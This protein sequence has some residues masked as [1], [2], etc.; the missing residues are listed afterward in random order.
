MKILKY[1][2]VFIVGFLFSK[3]FFH[4]FDIANYKILKVKS[5]SFPDSSFYQG[6][7]VDGKPNGK[8]ILTW[9]SGDEYQG[10]FYDG[11]IAGNGKFSWVNGDSYEGQVKDGAMHGEGKLYMA[12]GDVYT[13]KFSKGQ[14]DGAGKLLFL[15][16]SEYVG[17]FKNN[18][19]EEKG[20]LKNQ[21]GV[22]YIGSFKQG[23]YHGEGN[24][25]YSN[26]DVYIGAFSKGVLNGFGTYYLEYGDKYIG[27]YINGQLSGEGEY[28][29]E[30]GTKYTGNF[31]NWIYEGNGTFVNKDGVEYQGNFH[32]GLY[33]GVGKLKTLVS[34]YSGEFLY[35]QFHGKGELKYKDGKIY[36]GGFKGGKAN[37]D[38]EFV[39]IDG[40]ITNGFWI[41]NRLINEEVEIHL[42]S[43]K[44]SL[45]E[46][47]NTNG[48]ILN[49]S[50]Q[51][52]NNGT[53]GK[54]DTFYLLIAGDGTQQVFEKEIEFISK[55]FDPNFSLVL[56]NQLDYNGK[57]PLAT[58][59]SLKKA[60]IS[61]ESKMNI[62]EDV[63][64]LYMTSHGSKRGA[65]SIKH[66]DLNLNPI[67]HKELSALFGSLKIKNKII[68][69]SSCYSGVY[70]P[71]LKDE[72]TSILTASSAEKTSFGCSNKSDMTWFA[73]GFF[74]ELKG[75][76]IVLQKR[77]D[78]AVEKVKQWESEH[79]YQFSDPQI[80]IGKNAPTSIPILNK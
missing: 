19:F 78:H 69:I 72:Y 23:L 26:G 54:R 3:V 71:K 59:L 11:V 52:L 12:N 27:N 63:L 20:K 74:S 37:G 15:N 17:N 61:I 36:K 6:T 68:M 4:H 79:G 49:N 45:E 70:I 51:N 47:L 66:P 60:L 7:I 14:L 55:Y 35:G 33:Q 13:G 40:V 18:L 5:L 22:T 50:I 58:K 77:F 10:D 32:E 62:D 2:A 28:H 1:G 46:I 8:G 44:S 65:F 29:G 16:G 64:F 76:K 57:Y 48:L 56:A 25:K 31:E 42:D 38:G 53:D 80:W 21:D 41:N 34:D 75:T 73:K 24:I 43:K 30:N 67:Y 39:D 9:V